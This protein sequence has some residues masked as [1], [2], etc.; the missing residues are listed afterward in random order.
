MQSS[1]LSNNKDYSSWLF[2]GI[3]LSY[4]H[5][6]A[7]YGINETDGGFITAYAWRI[8]QG[9]QLYTELIYVRP[10]L[11]IWL[12]SLELWLLPDTIELIAERYLFY[13]KVA[14]YSY[15]AATLLEQ[16]TA[17]WWLATLGFIISVHCYPAAAWHTVDGIFFSVLA[18]WCLLKKDWLIAGSL[19]VV[20]AML[21]KQSFYPLLPM[22]LLLVALLKSRPALGKTVISLLLFAVLF[23]S[24]LWW[25]DSFAAYL[26]W[27][28]GAS[29]VSQA[30]QHGFWDY[31]KIDWRLWIACSLLVPLFFSKELL[32]ARPIWWRLFIGVILGSYLYT[33]YNHQSFSPP[34]DQSRLLFLVAAGYTAFQLGS[35][36]WWRI[37]LNEWGR[38]GKQWLYVAAL[39]AV[40]WMAAVSWGYNFPVLFAVPWIWIALKI[41]RAVQSDSPGKYASFWRYALLLALLFSFRYAYE[42]IY[43]DGRR[44]QMNQAMEEVFP[45]LKY[46]YSDKATFEKYTE[47]Y[48]LH[49]QYDSCFTVLPAF[50]LANYLTNTRS[51]VE[52]D[53][54]IH[55]ETNGKN[56]TILQ[57]IK[58]SGC[59]YFVEKSYGQQL[60]DRKKYVLTK[61]A[62]QALEK[63]EERNYFDVYH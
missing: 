54:V 21:C 63:I 15:L 52:L 51:P 12:R 44:S 50:P 5:L 7:P 62:M 9:E 28:S 47:L 37:P 2:F 39:L 26:E 41:D 23:I 22:F 10:P 34:V 42:F 30:I 59:Y 60:Q 4:L 57:T 40:S 45:K 16:S 43:R 49:Q 46:I 36:L 18:F 6:Y 11:S 13:L 33:I 55:A 3:V 17:K 29:S 27:T 14:G 19:S 35:F 31:F 1:N 24:Y 48:Q 56:S 25:A 20:L 61:Q 58:T 38:E 8:L 53:W 32:F